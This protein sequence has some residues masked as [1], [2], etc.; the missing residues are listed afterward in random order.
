[1]RAALVSLNGWAP[2][3]LTDCFGISRVILVALDIGL[4]I[5]GR[6]SRAS[7]P[8]SMSSRAQKCV[9]ARASRPYKARRQL[10]KKSHHLAA[11]Q[12]PAD[13][14]LLVAIYSVA[15]N[16]F[17]AISKPIV[18]I[19]MCTAPSCDSLQRSP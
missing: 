16:T 3:R 2:H 1:D 17:L 6:I 14:D 5:P 12:L 13:N 4:H 10:L 8:S 11:P 9:V 18:V 7:C 19:C 15:W